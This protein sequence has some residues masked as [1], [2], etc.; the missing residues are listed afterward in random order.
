[1]FVGLLIYVLVECLCD[2]VDA[3]LEVN[4]T[5]ESF[6]RINSAHRDSPQVR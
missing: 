5:P 1:M 2:E 3:L 6:G 4:E